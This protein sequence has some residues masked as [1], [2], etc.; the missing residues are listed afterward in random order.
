MI[1][2]QLLPITPPFV[3]RILIPKL[4]VVSPLDALTLKLYVLH[5]LAVTQVANA[6]L[7]AAVVAN[8]PD[9]V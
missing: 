9:P 6:Q 8:V 2:S 5:G 7:Y 1:A 3:P 4:A